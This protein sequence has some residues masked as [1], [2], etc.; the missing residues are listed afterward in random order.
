MTMAGKKLQIIYDTGTE[1]LGN[2][3]SDAI[4]KLTGQANKHGSQQK[5]NS[6]NHSAVIESK[7]QEIEGELHGTMDKSIKRLSKLIEQELEKSRQHTESLVSELRRFS[8][9]TQESIASIKNG[10]GERLHDVEKEVTSEFDKHFEQR[11]AV[12]VSENFERVKSLRQHGNTLTNG[13]QQKLDQNVWESKGSEKQI[14]S[15]LYKNYM[16]KASAIESHFSQI[17]Q[18]LSSEFQSQYKTAEDNSHKARGNVGAAI[19]KA[20]AQIEKVGADGEGDISQFFGRIV[21]DQEAELQAELERIS[22]DL[23]NFN[24]GASIN[25]KQKTQDYSSS[26]LTASSSAQDSLKSACQD[27][28]GKAD[29][30]HTECIQALD[31]KVKGSKQ[32]RSDLE[33]TKMETIKEICDELA[34]LRMA[35]EKN[36]EKLTTEAEYSVKKIADEVEKEIKM[37]HS[38]CL[39]KLQ[40]DGQSA[41]TE[42][43]TETKR[44]LDLIET[45]KKAALSDISAAAGADQ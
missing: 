2:I 33:T 24:Q 8:E 16:Q 18:K 36:L 17:M 35:F 23:S 42:I 21:N 29:V 20:L 43:E 19:E 1:S 10:M 40:E 13:L 34:E 41:Q 9:H 28:I 12:L 38:R 30:M 32:T 14:I 37:A 6:T 3:E 27:I 4:A 45:H 25:L 7:A 31:E 5:N 15:Q 44:L 26:L 39:N 11:V 22:K